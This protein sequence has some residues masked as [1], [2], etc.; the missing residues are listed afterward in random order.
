MQRFYSP[1]TGATYFQ[2]V[3]SNI[4]ADAQPIAE[5][6]YQA[7]ITNPAAGKV[8][9]HDEAGLPILI[10]PPA[11]PRSRIEHLAWESIKSERDRR[12][13]TGGYQANGYWFHSDQLS[14]D[15]QLKL[16]LAGENV[17]RV[18]WKTMSGEFVQMSPELAEAIVLASGDSDIAIFAAAEAHRAAMLAA[19]D[20]AAYDYSQDWPL[21]Y[22]E[23]AAQQEA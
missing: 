21:T 22:G 5:D 10:D 9:S 3:H 16:K 1:T 11:S 15:Q 12:T 14:R 7:V 6:L 8:R 4:P 2:G 19:A 18:A 20:P 23:W 13:L 17:P